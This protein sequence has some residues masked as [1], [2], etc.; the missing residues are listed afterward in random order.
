VGIGE[1]LDG[2]LTN[3]R[4]YFLEAL[5]CNERQGD[6]IGTRATRDRLSRASFEQSELHQAAEQWQQI[7]TE[8]RRQGDGDDIARSQL[9]LGQ[10][11]Y[12]WNK[13]EEAEQAAE[14]AFWREPLSSWLAFHRPATRRYRHSSV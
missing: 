7:Q 9:G 8:A 5:K 11:A 12:Q 10:I 4:E 3:A 6:L 14:E 2:S 1:L 13:L